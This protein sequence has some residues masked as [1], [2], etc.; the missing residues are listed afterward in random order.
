MRIWYILMA[1]FITLMM[2]MAIVLG[3]HGD[4][5]GNHRAIP[6]H[7][8]SACDAQDASREKNSAYPWQLEY[9][10]LRTNVDIAYASIFGS[11]R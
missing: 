11:P 6:S 7:I 4:I 10:T 2:T 3:S 5:Q 1:T 9:V 8:N